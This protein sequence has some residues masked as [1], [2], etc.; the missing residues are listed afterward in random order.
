MCHQFVIYKKDFAVR[1][2]VPSVKSLG[3]L[4]GG[5]RWGAE[6]VSAPR[7]GEPGEEWAG[8]TLQGAGPALLWMLPE[9][10]ETQICM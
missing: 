10:S 5:G 3:F 9:K 4:A 7:P 2:T 8:R 1:G 6:G